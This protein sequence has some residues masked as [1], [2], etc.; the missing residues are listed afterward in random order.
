MCLVIFI[1]GNICTKPDLEL[2]SLNLKFIYQMKLRK[3]IEMSTEQCFAS[4]KAPI[5]LQNAALS[6]VTREKESKKCERPPISSYRKL[7]STS[8]KTLRPHLDLRLKQGATYH[9][10]IKKSRLHN[11]RSR[12]FESFWFENTFG[13]V[14]TWGEGIWRCLCLGKTVYDFL[15]L[16]HL[17]YYK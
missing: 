10:E 13:R 9:K 11:K 4:T 7:T 2:S 12:F 16:V 1:S 3:R 17:F 14:C 6:L 5:R 15:D 8:L